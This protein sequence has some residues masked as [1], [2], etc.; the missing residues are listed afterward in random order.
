[1]RIWIWWS[2]VGTFGKDFAVRWLYECDNQQLPMQSRKAPREAANAQQSRSSTRLM[3]FHVHAVCYCTER[4]YATEKTLLLQTSAM[5][6]DGNGILS[7]R[8]K[9]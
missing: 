7:N 5:I 8:G 6:L 2:R 3:S 9:L 4:R 1:M